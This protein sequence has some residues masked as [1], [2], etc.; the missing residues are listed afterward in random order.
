MKITIFA[1]CFLCAAAAFGQTAV[2]YAN[3]QPVVVPSHPE[4]AAAHC[5]GTGIQSA[6]VIRLQL[7]SGRATAMGVCLR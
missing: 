1:L 7:W 6:P 5:H 4:H 3:P 2:L